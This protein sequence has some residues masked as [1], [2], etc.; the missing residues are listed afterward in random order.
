MGWEKTIA[1]Y[2]GK[3]RGENFGKS[4]SMGP[5]FLASVQQLM[6]DCLPSVETEGCAWDMWTTCR[7]CC[8][9]TNVSSLIPQS[10]T[11]ER[12]TLYVSFYSLNYGDNEEVTKYFFSNDFC[13]VPSVHQK[14]SGLKFSKSRTGSHV[15]YSCHH[16][17]SRFT[18][19]IFVHS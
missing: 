14:S 15:T 13:L 7:A 4:S 17:S 16:N 11:V 19:P 18:C 12:L 9:A 5:L 3:Y 10:D 6:I 2:S 8:F 1:E